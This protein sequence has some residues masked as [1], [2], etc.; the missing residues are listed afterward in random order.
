MTTGDSMA[1]ISKVFG[2]ILGRFNPSA[3]GDS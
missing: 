3:D 1:G 2:K